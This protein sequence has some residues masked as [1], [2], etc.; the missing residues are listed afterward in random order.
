MGFNDDPDSV[1]VIVKVRNPGYVP[2]GFEVRSRIDDIMFTAEASEAALT[3]AAGDP[4]V[5]SV[6]RARPLHPL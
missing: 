6:E 4:Q 3:A 5:K 1:R 2:E